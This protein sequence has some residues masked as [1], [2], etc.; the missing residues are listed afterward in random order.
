MV[1][2]AMQATERVVVGFIVAT[3]GLCVAL[4]TAYLYIIDASRVL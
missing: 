3:A 4:I 1:H 2:K